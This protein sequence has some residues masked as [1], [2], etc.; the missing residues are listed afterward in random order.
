MVVDR[1][2]TPVSGVV[3][4]VKV[5]IGIPVIACGVIHCRTTLPHGAI[6]GILIE[7]IIHHRQTEEAH[8]LLL[9]EIGEAE[10][11]D[12]IIR[13]ELLDLL[14]DSDGGVRLL[15]TLVDPRQ[16]LLVDHGALLRRQRQDQRLRLLV[17]GKGGEDAGLLTEHHGALE[18]VGAAL[19]QLQSA[20]VQP[21]IDQPLH[22]RLGYV[23]LSD[24]HQR[25]RTQKQPKQRLE[26]DNVP[27]R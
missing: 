3:E 16:Q 7:E 8:P 2:H 22:L 5:G 25:H 9:I 13:G 27:D 10:D 17:S 21:L 1:I 20:V 12:D 19:Q 6:V 4:E 23:S 18:T 14:T 11:I 26:M 15:H 24:R